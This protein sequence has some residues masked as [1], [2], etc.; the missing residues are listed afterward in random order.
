MPQFAENILR[1]VSAG[2]WF[3]AAGLFNG[4]D[5]DRWPLIDVS[6]TAGEVLVTA[7]LPGL[8][9]PGDVN[10]ELKGNSLFIEGEV[11]PETQP[12]VTIHKQERPRG[13]FSRVIILP[14]AVD[15]KNVR[16]VYHGGIMEIK[17]AKSPDGRAEFLNVDFIE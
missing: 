4:A 3:D 17:L 12:G 11:A 6:E 13:K 10:I 7:D 5:Q 1:E 2:D 16:A 8:K 15:A 9:G 14:T